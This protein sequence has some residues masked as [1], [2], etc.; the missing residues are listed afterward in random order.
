MCTDVQCG[1]EHVFNASNCVTLNRVYIYIYILY[2][3]TE[4]QVS[5]PA[6]ATQS[7]IYLAASSVCVCTF[8]KQIDAERWT[9]GDDGTVANIKGH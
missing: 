5:T 3:Y 4:P 8:R 9:C 2:I 6:R 1:I 7:T